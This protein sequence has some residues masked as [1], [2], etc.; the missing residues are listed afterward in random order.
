MYL[1]LIVFPLLGSISS[2]LFGRKIGV[3]GSHLLTCSFLA[4]TTIFSVMS[5]F[6]VG[7]NNI[8]VGIK[9]FR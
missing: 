5:F 8:A 7:F 4:I 9:L 1:T 3:K 2:G 6:E